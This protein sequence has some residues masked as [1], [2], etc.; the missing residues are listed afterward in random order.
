MAVGFYPVNC[1]I[2]SKEQKCLMII[3]LSTVNKDYTVLVPF[4]AIK[5]DKAF[6]I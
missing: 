5:S 6:Q 3:S 1:M 2:S 4:K